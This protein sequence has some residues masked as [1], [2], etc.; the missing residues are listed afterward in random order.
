MSNLNFLFSSGLKIV[1]FS[2]KDRV[3]SFINKLRRVQKFLR[4]IKMNASD[5][6]HDLI[7]KHNYE[8]CSLLCP[9]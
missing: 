5:I 8:T 1:A 6:F 9:L 4:I 3:Q 2:V 7:E